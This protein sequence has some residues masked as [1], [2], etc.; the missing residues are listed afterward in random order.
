[1]WAPRFA[2]ACFVCPPGCTAP[3]EAISGAC[4]AGACGPGFRDLRGAAP[5]VCERLFNHKPHA[6]ASLIVPVTATDAADVLEHGP[7]CML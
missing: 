1:M 5:C 6:N 3:C 4:S 2:L 7:H